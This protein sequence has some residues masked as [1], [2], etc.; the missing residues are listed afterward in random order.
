MKIVELNGNGKARD[1]VMEICKGMET[2]GT[3]AV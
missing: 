1:A 3:D 2:M